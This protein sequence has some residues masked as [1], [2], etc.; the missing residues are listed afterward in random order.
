VRFECIQHI[1][2]RFEVARRYRVFDIFLNGKKHWGDRKL[3]ADPNYRDVVNFHLVMRAMS[4][5]VIPL[6][7]AE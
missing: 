2:D 1:P 7:A 3:I 6:S 5:T 4:P